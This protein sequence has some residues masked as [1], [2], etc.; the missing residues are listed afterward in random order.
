LALAASKLS[1][2]L[3]IGSVSL[4]AEAA[5]SVADTV[6]QGFLLISLNLSDDPADEDHPFGHG[7]DRFFWAL[8]TAVFIF[9]A[10]AAF[11]IYE[12]TRQLVRGGTHEGSS[13]LGYLVLGLG[14]LFD[15]SVFV[16][17]LREISG[18][19]Q[20]EK[21]G[22]VQFLKQSPDV[23]LKAALFE[24]SA[25]LVG[26]AIAA[27]GLYAANRTGNDDY[28]ANASILIG[29]VLLATATALGF[30]SRNLLLVERERDPNPPR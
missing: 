17:S 30:Q 14:L 12:G 19:L 16:T 4:L 8:L 1:V 29:L 10:G 22:F 21:I 7:K 24:D 2:G 18:R 27:V 6:N 20:Q 28:E 13:W 9:V 3:V 25:A 23:T 5:H 11:S 15:D 26:I